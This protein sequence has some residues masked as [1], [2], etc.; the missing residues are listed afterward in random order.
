VPPLDRDEARAR[1]HAVF[2]LMNSTPHL[3][4]AADH[5]GTLKAM[6]LAALRT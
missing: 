4:D 5:A 3:P 1:A 2:G 6:A